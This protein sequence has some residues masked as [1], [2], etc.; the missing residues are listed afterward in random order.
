MVLR[1]CTILQLGNLRLLNTSSYC[2][3]AIISVEA[4]QEP[5]SA[6]LRAE[7]E[8]LEL[9]LSTPPSVIAPLLPMAPQ[10]LALSGVTAPQK[11][12]QKYGIYFTSRLM[13]FY[14]PETG[15]NKA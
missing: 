7:T 12:A 11:L 2:Q 5:L 3:R 4:P 1:P 8:S 15:E 13:Y 6:L 14:E 10:A 9:P